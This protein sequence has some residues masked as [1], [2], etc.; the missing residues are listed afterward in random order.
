MRENLNSRSKLMAVIM[1]LITSLTSIQ[2]KKEDVNPTLP[3]Q[4]P[5]SAIPD[6]VL[7]AATGVVSSSYYVVNSL[8]SGYVKDGSRDYTTYIQAAITKYPNVVLPPFPVLVNDNGITIPSNRVITFPTGSEIRLKPSSKPG[9]KILNISN[10]TNITLYNPVITGDRYKHIGTT[11]EWGSGI[12]IYGSSNISIYGAKIKDCWGDGIYLGQ[13]SGKI[14]PK[15]IIIKDSSLKS[16]RRAGM[17][18]I[19]VDGLLLENVYAGY[20]KGTV[21]AT[22]INFEANYPTSELKNVQ[23][24][25]ITTE[26]NGER[27]IQITGHHMLNSSINKYVNITITNHIDKSSPMSAIKFS[28]NNVDGTSAKMLGTINIVNPS[29]Q[30]TL[31]NRPLHIITNQLGMKMTVSSPDVI[32]SS[33][34]LLSWASTYSLLDKTSSIVNVLRD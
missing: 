17:S 5:L 6:G 2:C 13:V 11:G 3:D 20:N 23:M 18:I 16:N 10:A 1:L 22:G 15:N 33:G 19:G 31:N 28:V 25:N 26:L 9:Y 29:W 8:P 27:G 30:K 12:A 21:P 4:A 14:N 32:N 24:K 34:S 7:M